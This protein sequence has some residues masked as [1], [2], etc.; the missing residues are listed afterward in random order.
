MRVDAPSSSLVLLGG[1]TRHA[2]VSPRPRKPVTEEAEIL[3]RVT[4][5]CEAAH[6]QAVEELV[7]AVRQFRSALTNRAGSD[8]LL[9]LAYDI[10]RVQ[11]ALRNIRAALR[12]LR[13]ESEAAA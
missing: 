9:L 4:A 6:G 5:E 7:G 2:A 13:A 8:V 3:E 11:R 10:H 12:R 1:H